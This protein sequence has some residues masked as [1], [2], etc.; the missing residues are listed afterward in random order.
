MRKLYVVFPDEIGTIAPEIYGHFTEHIGGVIYDGI[1][2]G[3]DSE[4]ENVDGFRKFIIDKL[5][6]IH[7]AVVRWPGGCFAE[8]YN[9][10]DGI[11]D[12]RPTRLNWWTRSD[13]KYET[14]EVGTHEFMR[15]CELIGAE[16]YLAVNIASSTAREMREWVDYCNSPEGTTTCARERAAN[17]HP[18]PF[19]V[20][21]WGIGNESWEAGGNM[22]VDC[23]ANEYR[24]YSELCR[25]VP[26]DK[27]LIACG[28]NTADY[29]WTAEFM[30][31][32]Q[33]SRLRMRGLSMHYYC[34]TD[35][36]VVDFTK[37]EWYQVVS[38]AG[39]MDELINR[40]W[41]IIRGYKME[42]Y[43]RLVIDEWGCWHPQGTGPSK[44][45][46]LLEQ[47]STVRDALVS[48]I[49]LNVFNNNCDKVM[50]A[51]VAQ[52]VNNLHALFLSAGDKCI[53]TPTYHVFKMF[54]EHQNGTAVK[55][56][57]DK[58][59]I[60]FN[61]KEGKESKVEDLTVSASY[62]EDAVILTITNVNADQDVEFA[63]EAVGKKLAQDAVMT[64]LTHEDYRACN[65][66]EDPDKVATY[67]VAIDTANPIVIPKASV[68][69]I[70]ASI[71]A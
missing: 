13:G 43:A 47:Q 70:K 18:E 27:D 17:G 1:W 34:A 29:H 22:S 60:T 67:E 25:N 56:C 52:M 69:S 51:N 7:P 46:N 16:P 11:G 35:D 23:Y 37:D 31:R 26:G 62:K 63:L 21:Y 65:T 38:S 50:M 20:K 61:N 8:T 33:N 30:K 39:Y 2:V 55:C 14:N 10:R 12:E 59:Y 15:F 42:E 54:A 45:K 57:M 44:G 49:T 5:K 66:F 4:V 40:H 58:E 28:P 3:K 64:V 41:G 32:M 68:V 9:W 53:T 36:K 71:V 19:N 24:K 48:A 6:D